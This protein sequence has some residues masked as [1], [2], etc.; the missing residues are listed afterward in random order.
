MITDIRKSLDGI[1]ESIGW[2]ASSVRTR[3]FRHT[4]CAA[5]LQS[6]D[7]G[8]PIATY[9]VARELGH[10]GE[11]LLHRVAAPEVNHEPARVAHGGGL[12]GLGGALAG[13]HAASPAAAWIAFM[14]SS[15]S[16]CS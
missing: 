5:R 8:H 9:T 6:V 13:A 1:A 4:Y 11:G 14:Y 15:S 3:L 16:R 10:G 7:G 12:G 2:E